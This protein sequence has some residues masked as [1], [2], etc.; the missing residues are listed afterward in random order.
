[1]L[2]LISGILGTSHLCY[3]L[4]HL[5]LALAFLL[6]TRHPGHLPLVMRCGINCVFAVQEIVELIPAQGAARH[7][8][9]TWG[10][11][12]AH[13]CTDRFCSRSSLLAQPRGREPEPTQFAMG[14]QYRDL[15]RI[16]WHNRQGRLAVPG[17]TLICFRC[18][19]RPRTLLQAF[20]KIMRSC[21]SRASETIDHPHHFLSV[22]TVRQDS[23][24]CALI[25]QR[26][27]LH[28]R[29][30]GHQHIR[31]KKVTRQFRSKKRLLQRFRS[32]TTA[33]WAECAQLVHQGNCCGHS[34]RVPISACGADHSSQIRCWEQCFSGRIARPTM[35]KDMSQEEMSVGL[36]CKFLHC[37]PSKN[38]A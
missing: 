19:N 34:R 35:P 5:R 32:S 17:A 37:F 14:I 26:R 21:P 12:L 13:V 11:G 4:Q 23:S 28:L 1:M 20:R 18:Q 3:L 29:C 25:Q 33:C 38:T 9:C 7:S 36:V 27:P 15:K 8:Q 10:L 22:H 6:K 30:R 16:H 2:I 31:T 24:W